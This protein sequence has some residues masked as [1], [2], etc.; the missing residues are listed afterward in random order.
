M[1]RAEHPPFFRQYTM[2]LTLKLPLAFAAILLLAVAA[3]LYGIRT[4]N[5]SVEVYA[6]QVQASQIA[7]VTAAEIAIDFKTQVQEWKNTLIRG[8]DAQKL[9]HHWDKFG[10]QERSVAEKAGALANEIPAGEARDLLEKFVA[11]HDSMGRNYRRAFAEFK[12]SGMDPAVGDAAVAGVDRDAVTLLDTAGKK[13]AAQSTAMSAQAAANAKQA[14]IVSLALMGAV[15]LAGLVGGVVFSRTI[16]RP[17]GRAVAVASAVAEG[18]LSVR[19]ETNGRDETAQLLR[20][21]GAMRDSLAGVVENVRQNADSVATA[22][23]Q[24]AQGNNDLSGR[25]EQQASALQ[26]TAASMTQLSTTVRLNADNAQEADKLAGDASAVAERGGD[27]VA[28]VVDTMKGIDESSRR[29]VEIIG[30]IDGIAFQTNILAL[31]AAVEAARAGEQGRGFAV[32]ASE[33]RSLAKRSADAARQVKELIDTSVARVREGTALVDEAGATMTE[34][35]GSI[36]RVKSVVG[37]ISN[38]SRE[39]SAG[40]VQVGQAVSQMDQATQQNAA[41]VEESAAAA[42]TLSYQ[43]QQL[44]AAVAIFKLE[45]RAPEAPA[46]AGPEAA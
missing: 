16:T 14:T 11:A 33:V 34:V 10:E 19:A 38:A 44:V 5:R 36:E 24:I 30:V 23:A 45:G 31:N 35:V 25:T 32:V 4:L 12:N 20:A 37:E 17:L 46:E 28:R 6:T 43:A 15:C 27:V 40:V 9:Q 42:D 29:I 22:S 2:K 1:P 39:Q 41:L 26:E 18:D 3:A 7:E 13:I 8:K 21:L